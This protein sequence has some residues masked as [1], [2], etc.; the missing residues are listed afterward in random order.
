M[1]FKM[2]VQMSGHQW[3]CAG[4][5]SGVVPKELNKLDIAV[6]SHPIPEEQP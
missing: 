6:N 2:E 4:S 3:A 1:P 5:R